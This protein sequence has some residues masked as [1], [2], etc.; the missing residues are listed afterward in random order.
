M[1]FPCLAVTEGPD[2]GKWFPLKPGTGNLIG[3]FQ[4][5]AYHLNDPRVSRFHAELQVEGGAVTVLDNGGSGGTMVNGQ[6]VTSLALRPGD[7]IQLGDSTLRYLTE[8]QGDAETLKKLP[9]PTEYDPAATDQLAELSGQAVSH[10]QVGRALGKGATG[11][12]FR[13]TDTKTNQAVAL[14]V[15]QPAFARNDDDMQRFVRAM[16]AMLPL[17]H[18][19]IV[20]VYAAG[21]SGPH[22]WAAMELVEGES[23]TEVIRRIGVAGMLDWKHAYRVAVHIG[24]ALAYA[25]GKGI[26]HRDISPANV[27]MRAADKTAVLGDLMLAKALEGNAARQI[28]RPGELVGDVNYMS[29]ERT[30]G[31][32]APDPRSDLFSLGATCYALLTGK[33]PFAGANLIETITNLRTADPAKPSAFQMGIPSSFEGAVLKLLAKKPA[34][35]YQTADELVADLERIGKLAGAT[36]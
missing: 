1:D 31:G 3:R 36:A 27:M 24:R 4:D 2:K 8:P 34:E 19:N 5:V 32:E 22:C 16:Q 25:H 11:M 15:M 35:R 26:V 13:A 20:A 33:P 21:K 10:Y 28:T 23:M 6:K 30:G 7:S 17:K 29:P 18:P 9:V 14:K 12:V